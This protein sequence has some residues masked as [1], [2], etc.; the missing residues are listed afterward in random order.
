VTLASFLRTVVSVLEE[1]GTPYMLTG[2]LAGAYYSLPRATQDIDFV[3]DPGRDQVEDLV[4]RFTERGYYVSSTAAQEAVRHHGQFNVV[5]PETGWKVDLIIRKDRTFSTE[6][7]SRRRPAEV[8][9]VSVSLTSPEDLI[10]AKLEWAKLGDSALQ[11]RDV[12]QLARFQWESLDHDYI[13]RWA[14][15]LG[16]KDNWD[17]IVAAVRSE[18]EP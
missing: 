8:L 13:D 15:E 1:S 11:R 7:F 10:L 12:A 5:D 3:L 2:S 17:V 9:G 16:T 18:R 6:E 14:A 4:R